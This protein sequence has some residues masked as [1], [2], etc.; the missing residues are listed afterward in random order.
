MLLTQCFTVL[1]ITYTLAQ[2]V[3]HGQDFWHSARWLGAVSG[4]EIL[5]LNMFCMLMHSAVCFLAYVSLQD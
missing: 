4:I 2:V 5:S 1:C 3:F